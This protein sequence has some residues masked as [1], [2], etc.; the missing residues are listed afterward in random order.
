MKKSIMMIHWIPR[1]LCILAILFVSMFA[2][3]SFAP[4]MTLWEQIGAFLMHLIPTFVLI[5]FL[6]VAWKWEL[7]GGIMFLII[8][9][10]L[11]PLIYMMNY[12]M[13]HS[14]WISVSII[15]MINLPFVLVGILFV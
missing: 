7:I 10:G 4:G 8:G 6:I 9:L 1:I 15:L 14:V 11:L 2:L 13:N 3:D 12:Q 5:L